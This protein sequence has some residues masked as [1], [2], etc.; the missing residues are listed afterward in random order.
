M[1]SVVILLM[2]DWIS[3]VLDRPEGG[4]SDLDVDAVNFVKYPLLA[5]MRYGIVHMKAGDCLFI[6]WRW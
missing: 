4:Y 2:Q 3:Q 6:P 5:N 1:R